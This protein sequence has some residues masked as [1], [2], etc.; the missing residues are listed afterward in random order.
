MILDKKET[1]V[2]YRCPACGASVMSMVGIFALTADMIRL[3]CPCGGSQLEIVYTKDKKVRLNVPCFLCPSPHTY[4]VSSQ[5]FFDRELFSLPCSYSGFDICFIGRQEKVAEAMQKAEKELLDML[6]ESD[7]DVETLLHSVNHNE[8]PE[9]TD[10]QVLDIVLYV[11]RD[12]AEE[13]KITCSCPDGGDY[14]VEIHDDYLTVKC[15]Q[16]GDSLDVPTNSL[17]A[18]NDFLA[19]ERLDLE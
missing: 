17:T 3:K 19:C 14:D 9:L 6:E 13:G 16:C 12:L 18:A 2:A 7:I 4:M 8:K 11:V 15:K 5:I 1:T 10:P